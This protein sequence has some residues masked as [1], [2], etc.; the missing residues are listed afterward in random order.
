MDPLEIIER[1]YRPGTLAH[2]LLV[3]HSRKVA[4]KAVE[5]AARLKAG[6]DEGFLYEA[7]MLHD[8]GIFLTDAP[9]LGCFGDRPYICHGYLGRELLEKEGLA[10]HAL[11]AERHVGVGLTV[12]DIMEQKLPL[13]QR[14]MTPRSEAE[15]I[16]CFADKFYSKGKDPERE[17]SVWEARLLV[18]RYGQDKL[19]IF[20]GWLKL[21]N[22]PVR[23]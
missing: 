19:D 12:K 10:R 6:A 2:R 18:G 5:T 8:I 14:D 23:P 16:I 22:P 17:K 4:E 1:F 9:G 20:D 13:P 15:I 11:V 21:F 3:S 7:A